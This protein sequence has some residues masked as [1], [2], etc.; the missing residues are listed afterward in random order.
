MK[1]TVSITTALI[2]LL[3]GCVKEPVKNEGSSI[4]GVLSKNIQESSDAVP[5]DI[6]RVIIS[7]ISELPEFKKAQK[8]IASVTGG[9]SGVSFII[10]NTENQNCYSVQA[11]YNGEDRFETYYFFSLEPV[12]YKIRILDTLTDEYVTMDVWRK[13]ELKRQKK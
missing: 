1:I 8:N 9:K 13:R 12:T 7:R 4:S 2:L 5:D 11:G 6:Q 3:T 10:D